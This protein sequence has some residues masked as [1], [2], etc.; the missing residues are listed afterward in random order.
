MMTVG[1]DTGYGT[2]TGNGIGPIGN[3]R[4][5]MGTG[6]ISGM[7]IGTVSRGR[8]EVLVR[9]I[10]DVLVMPGSQ[11]VVPPKE[12]VGLTVIGRVVM[13]V[14]RV[15]TIEVLLMIG[16]VV[17]TIGRVVILRSGRV[18]LGGLGLIS[19][20]GVGLGPRGI[21][22]RGV[23]QGVPGRGSGVLVGCL[24]GFDA[25]AVFRGLGSLVSLRVDVGRN[26][27]RGGCVWRAGAGRL[28]GGLR[29]V[30]AGFGRPA[31]A[32][33]LGVGGGAASASTSATSATSASAR[34]SGLAAA[35]PSKRMMVW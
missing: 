29:E 20:A 11:I 4:G 2:P 19:H 17:I 35:A 31:K 26:M 16:R 8:H 21:D 15:I 18:V 25:F 12:I 24:N 10:H 34:T 33:G 23:C 13:T 7:M 9:V 5:P 22:V 30:G 6:M 28:T 1:P 3:G 14:G 27:S 32:L